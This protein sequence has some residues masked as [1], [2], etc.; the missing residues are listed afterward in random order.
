[1]ST[2]TEIELRCDGVEGDPYGCDD[3]I[4]DLTAVRVRV[5]AKERGWLVN[6]RGKDYC[7]EHRPDAAHRAG[8]SS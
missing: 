7:P 3:V 2:Y 6:S 8:Q 4:Y 5:T 1:M